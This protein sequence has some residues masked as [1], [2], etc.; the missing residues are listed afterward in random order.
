MVGGMNRRLF[1]VSTVALLLLTGCSAPAQ[2]A[3][4]EPAEPSA[5]SSTQSEAPLVA[6]SPASPEAEAADSP[7]V[8]FL[9]QVREELGSDSSIPNATDGQLLKAGEDACAQIAGGKDFSQV[10]V[11]EGETA[12]SGGY[13]LDSATIARVAQQTICG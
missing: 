9:A 2:E 4:V 10:S 3:N 8:A 11:I 13:F 5:V 1:A 6:E 7:E 12:D